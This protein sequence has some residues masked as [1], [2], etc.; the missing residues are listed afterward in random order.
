MIKLN[1]ELALLN[2]NINCSR[3]DCITSQMTLHQL[4]HIT[5]L[6]ITLYITLEARLRSVLFIS[7]C[8]SMYFVPFDHTTY[9]H[10]INIEFCSWSDGAATM[11]LQF[12]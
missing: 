12:C 7:K 2:D 4:C 9:T 3:L 1:K 6:E 10:M 5:I 8:H 11:L